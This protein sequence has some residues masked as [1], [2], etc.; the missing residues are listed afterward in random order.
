MR[1]LF[2]A[3]PSEFSAEAWLKS[4][5]P[6]GNEDHAKQV[7]A[8][9]NDINSKSKNKVCVCVCPARGHGKTLLWPHFFVLDSIRASHF[10][11]LTQNAP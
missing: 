10:A 2:H 1:L 7:L 5:V 11:I 9:A 6:A 4:A 3:F 8:I